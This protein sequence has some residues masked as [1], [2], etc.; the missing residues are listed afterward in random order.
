MENFFK[1][2]N[3][4]PVLK[5][6]RL[7][8]IMSSEDARIRTMSIISKDIK[9]IKGPALLLING[10]DATL[11]ELEGHLSEYSIDA[12]E[13]M[14]SSKICNNLLPIVAKYCTEENS[15][16]ITLF[17]RPTTIM[18][19]N[20]RGIIDQLDTKIKSIDETSALQETLNTWRLA[21]KDLEETKH[22][23]KEADIKLKEAND[24]LLVY[25]NSC[26]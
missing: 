10:K 9:D 13:F 6:I 7:V 25:K 11:M 21:I 2:F 4:L 26:L 1:L 16:P 19:S 23:F 14:T 20:G 3:R 24:V 17:Y 22:K 5:Q 12:I 18:W 15:N 8:T